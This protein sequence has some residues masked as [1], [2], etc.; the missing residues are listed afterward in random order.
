[1]NWLTIHR[2]TAL[3][4][5]YILTV[6]PD[7]ILSYKPLVGQWTMCL[8]SLLRCH[9]VYWLLSSSHY[10]AR[11]LSDVV[12]TGVVRQRCQGRLLSLATSVLRL[13]SAHFGSTCHGKEK[14]RRRGGGVYRVMRRPRHNIVV[15]M[16]LAWLIIW[17]LDSL[18]GFIG[19]SL[20]LQSIITVYTLNSFWT[21][22]IWQKCLKNLDL[23]SQ[24]HSLLYLSRDPNICHPVKQFS[25]VILF[26][27]TG[28]SLL[29]F[30]AAE[31]DVCILL[32]SKLTN[33]SAAIT[34]YRQYL[35]SR[36][37]AVDYSVTSF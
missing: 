2:L 19:I 10:T 11:L 9:L 21:T 31:T 27:P 15:C 7:H 20:Q 14:H 33:T 35:L 16:G 5:C 34:A 3:G 32:P 17:V 24:I 28:M 23:I 22:S 1:M 12:F 37:L 8:V 30:V 26:V 6:A 4:G 29:I 18:I 36:C 25:S 13:R